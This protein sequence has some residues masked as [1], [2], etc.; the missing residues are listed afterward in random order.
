MLGYSSAR[1][2]RT[3][4]VERY[5]LRQTGDQL[6]QNLIGVLVVSVFMISVRYIEMPEF[7]QLTN[8]FDEIFAIGINPHVVET[9]RDQMRHRLKKT[10]GCYV[11]RVR[12]IQVRQFRQGSEKQTVV[13]SLDVEAIERQT[14]QFWSFEN[15]ASVTIIFQASRSCGE[16]DF[17]KL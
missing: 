2:V 9:Q 17:V 5:Q 16:I 3:A 14:P 10:E 6:G 13:P 1:E 4:D 12:K 7:L 8:I 11:R 15:I